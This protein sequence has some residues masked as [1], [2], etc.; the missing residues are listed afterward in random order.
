MR[1]WSEWVGLWDRTCVG[2][3][4]EVWDRGSMMEKTPNDGG[5]G[6]TLEK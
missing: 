3:G 1:M 4:R 6:K 2:G 5:I